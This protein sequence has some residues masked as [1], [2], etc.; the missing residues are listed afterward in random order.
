MPHCVMA[1]QTSAVPSHGIS[2]CAHAWQRMSSTGKLANCRSLSPSKNEQPRCFGVLHGPQTWRSKQHC[3]TR[4]SKTELFCTDALSRKQMTNTFRRR[5][6]MAYT[7]CKSRLK[8]AAVPILISE[9]TG[10]PVVTSLVRPWPSHAIA[11]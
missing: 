2:E 11:L 8:D 1:C 9:P 5:E 6:Q 10:A 4:T 7:A 3:N